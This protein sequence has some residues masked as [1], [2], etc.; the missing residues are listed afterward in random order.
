MVNPVK[1][2]CI[3]LDVFTD[4]PFTGNQLAVFPSA[5]DLNDIQMQKLANEINYSETVF[6]LKSEDPQADYHIRIFTPKT[7]LPF[8]GHPTLGA[9]YTI[10][11]IIDN[12][13][14][15]QNAVRLQTK[16]G[17][18]A[19]ERSDGTIWMKQNEPEFF[20][21][22]KDRV[23]IADLIGLEEADISENLPIE[24]V[25]TGNSILLVPI[26]NLSIIHKAK[27]NINK[28]TEFFRNRK[29]IA[30]YLFT[31][32]TEEPES[33]VHTRLFAPHL[34]ILEDPATGSAAGPLAAY[35][36]KHDVFG[37]QFEIQNEQGIEMG[38]PSRILM[39]GCNIDG[40]FKIEIGG[41]CHFI[42][43]STFNI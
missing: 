12:H 16:V 27:G 2:E 18:I 34:G 35:L 37:S 30:P 11:N 29:S 32:E 17:I 13:L 19:L 41:K 24:E 7:E 36:L 21:I 33:K 20:Q 38:R 5:D 39:R 22:Y 1:K 9:A 3:L 31:L 42:G 10:L 6:I 14:K 26:K 23:Q 8:A 43:H 4:I 15:D 28:I 40:K 25:S